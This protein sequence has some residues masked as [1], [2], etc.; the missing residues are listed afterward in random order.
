MTFILILPII[1]FYIIVMAR[2]HY[3]V[4]TGICD[5]ND[6][7]LWNLALVIVILA[8]CMQIALSTL[9]YQFA[10]NMYLLFMVTFSFH[11][12]YL[13]KRLDSF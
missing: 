7:D 8:F 2:L 3:Q 12:Y 4:K 11:I 9:G 13:I 10:S 1:L 5:F 6:K